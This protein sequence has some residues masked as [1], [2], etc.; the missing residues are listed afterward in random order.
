MTEAEKQDEQ[1]ADEDRD[2]DAAGERR[3]DPGEIDERRACASRA[4]Q[5]LMLSSQAASAAD[6]RG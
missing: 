6:L 2:H 5:S 3:A 4:S 1:H